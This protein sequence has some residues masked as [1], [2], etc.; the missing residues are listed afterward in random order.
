MLAVEKK[1]EGWMEPVFSMVM[2]VKTRNK[3]E[4]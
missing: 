2:V 4:D 1:D 3:D